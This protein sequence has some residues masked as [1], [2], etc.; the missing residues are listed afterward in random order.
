MN[1][2]KAK[3][4]AK[5][6]AC[7]EERDAILDAMVEMNG[8]EPLVGRGASLKNSFGQWLSGTPYF[9]STFGERAYRFRDGEAAQAFI[10][11]HPVLEDC[12]VH[13][14]SS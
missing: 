3:A 14:W 5:I 12:D 7:L 2:A 4:I 13:V 8:A 9:W 11:A 6:A 10:E 1:K